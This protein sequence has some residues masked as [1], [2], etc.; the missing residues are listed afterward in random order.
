M[1]TR[2]L[3]YVAAVSAALA[4]AYCGGSDNVNPSHTMSVPGIS[5]A[6]VYSFD[7][8]AVDPATDIYYV[9][10]RTNK[11]IDVVNL[12]TGG[13]SQFKQ[14][15]AGCNSTVGTTTANPVPM[16]GCNTISG[17]WTVNNDAS[18]P[19]GLDI[20][21]NALFVGDVNALWVLNKTTGAK[22]FKI[23][24]PSS[25]T[26]LRADEGCFDPVNHLYAISTPGA[27]NPFMT[28][29]DTTAFEATGA[30]P[31]IIATVI[32]DNPAG[33]AS[34][35][36]EAC[37][38]DTGVGGT[39]KLFVNND[40]NNNPAAPA[41]A[42]R[43]EMDGI[44][45]AALLALKPGPTTVQ[46]TTLAGNSQFLL[47]DVVGQAGQCDPTGIALGPGND[48]GAM[49]RTGTIG[50]SLNFLIL[51][52]TTGAVTATVAGGGGG[53]QITYSATLNKWFL[54]DSRHT[55]SG[56]SCG[57]GSTG[58]VLKPMLGIVDGT[59]HALSFIANGNNSHS[60]A[61]DE[62]LGVAITPFTNSSATGGGADFP[63]GGINIFPVR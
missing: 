4:L 3:S 52:K 11:A 18:G 26:G 57:A 1:R 33:T 31:T 47:P 28:I 30:T 17:V 42:S 19:D 8:G 61:V 48:I 53:D 32:M 20:V 9:T 38:F 10:D 45:T 22:L 59:T 29:L 2:H 21:G 25:P 6:V 46:Y 62:T 58:C 55:D 41:G 16:P 36:L 56:N 15:F 7:L 5:S 50:R 40:G 43:G 39:G 27:D 44:P 24:I 49:C 14:S 13:I 37:V 51:N 12:K 35:G 60:V 34:G 54:A 23:T 63:G